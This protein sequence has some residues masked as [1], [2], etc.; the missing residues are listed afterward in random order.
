MHK[1]T[2]YSN[3]PKDIP[4]KLKEIITDP[5]CFTSPEEAY[6]YCLY[7]YDQSAD[8]LKEMSKQKNFDDSVCESDITYPYIGCEIKSK[9]KNASS[10][11]L[12]FY[13]TTITKPKIFKDFYINKMKEIT[14]SGGDIWVGKSSYPMSLA[15]VSEDLFNELNLEK[16][17]KFNS[18]C[19]NR[20]Q[21]GLSEIHKQESIINISTFHAEHVDYSLNRLH[22]YCGTNAETFQNNIVF[23]NY[24]S[25]VDFFLEDG[26][27]LIEEGKYESMTGPNFHI[28]KNESCVKAN[29]N[30]Q[31]PAYHLSLPNRR[32]I[33]LINIGVGP[34]NAKNITDHLAVLKPN[35]WTMLGH[36][37]GL[38]SSQEVG[39]YVLAQNYS[40]HDHVLDPYIANRIPIPASKELTECLEES[41]LRN[42]HNGEKLHKGTIATTGDRNWELNG[43]MV[44]E[45][46]ESN[47]IAVDMESATIATNGFR[48][49][50][51]CLT[52]LCISDMPLH[53]KLKLKGMAQNFYETRIRTH[54]NTG[55]EAVK[56]INKKLNYSI[57]TNSSKKGKKLVPFR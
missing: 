54:F 20:I 30:P 35:S 14:S 41:V 40:R 23:T 17:M 52:F 22:H 49:S 53:R 24:Q 45:F 37:A 2:D 8:L 4:S 21:T 57:R 31:M 32:G 34:S 47:A 48:F 42:N 9:K 39:D 38:H 16:R 11:E 27:K 19:I 13:G 50:V 25:Y 7:L 26:K 44:K 33:T 3:I 15:F 18:P 55:M 6:N 10:L 1:L 36:C 12:G 51:P 46:S 43:E 56:N 5:K 29:T 28:S